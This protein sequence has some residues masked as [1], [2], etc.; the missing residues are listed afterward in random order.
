MTAPRAQA[1]SC[2]ATAARA[3]AAWVQVVDAQNQRDELVDNL[4][5]LLEG[6]KPFPADAL[7]LLSRIQ[8][9]AG[10]A[11]ELALEVVR[12]LGGIADHCQQRHG[13]AHAHRI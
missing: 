3:A 7:A 8:E 13:E 4:V 10:Y 2:P 11:D 9:R 12:L 5:D 6:L 1:S